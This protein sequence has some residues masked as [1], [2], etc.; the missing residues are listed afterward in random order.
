MADFPNEDEFDDE[1]SYEAA[2]EAW[3]EREY[4]LLWPEERTFGAICLCHLGCALRQWLIV[5]G[6]EAGRV[7]DDHRADGVDM[8][9]LYDAQGRPMGFADWYLG[10][11]SAP[12]TTSDARPRPPR[13]HGVRGSVDRPG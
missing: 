6:P 2:Y 8:D 10:Q 7:W 3:Q 12:L 9:P 4:Q 11:G 1:D 13:D 5:S